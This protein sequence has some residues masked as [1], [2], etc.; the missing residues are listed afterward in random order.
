MLKF[1]DVFIICHVDTVFLLHQVAP[2]GLK[3]VTTM[4][5]GSCS[6]ENALKNIFIWYQHKQRG[7][8]SDFSR[9]ETESCMVNQS[10]GSPSLSVMSFWGNCEYVFLL[11]DVTSWQV[12]VRDWFCISCVD[13]RISDFLGRY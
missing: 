11:G 10:P 8:S 9:E 2:P 7:G 1:I 4:M 5:C 13:N 3:H 6:N 12:D